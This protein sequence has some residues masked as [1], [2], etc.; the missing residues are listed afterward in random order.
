MSEQHLVIVG[1]VAAGPKIAAKARRENP[2]IPITLITDEPIISYAGCGTPYYLG[3]TFK[4]RSQLL[5]RTVG[6]FCAKNDTTM[7]VE[8]RVTKIDR[9]AHTLEVL[10]LNKQTTRT[11]AYSKLALATGA[12]AFVPPLEGLPAEG[13]F[14]LRSVTDAFAIDDWINLHSVRQVAIVGA[15]YIGLEMAE[16]LRERGLQVSVIE[17]APQV[18]PRFDVTVAKAV[19]RE[20]ERLGC[21][22]LLDTKVSG[23]QTDHRNKVTAVR[24]SKGPV[25]AEMVILSIGVRANTGLAKDAGLTIGKTGAIWVDHHM[26]TSDPDIYAA[27][28]CAE[29]TNRQTGEP[30]WVPLGSTANKQGRVAAVNMTGGHDHFPGVIGTALVRV[31]Q[32]N[33]GV[34][35]LGEMALVAGGYDYESVAVPVN[36][37]PGYI[38]GSAE[39]TLILHADR[40]SRKV[41]G[42]Q[43]FGPGEVDK[44]IDILATAITAGMTI[45]DLANL[46]LGY[47]PP[48]AP[49]MDAVIVAGNVLRNKLDGRTASQLPPQLEADLEMRPIVL[50]DC[51][52][53]DEY[54]SG[55]LPG[56]LLMPLGTIDKR[57]HELDPNAET[58]VYCKRGGRS[59]S[60]YRKLK[61]AGLK[62]VRY[63]EG[64]TTGW[65]GRTER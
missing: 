60:G 31:G 30:C 52:E 35:G 41:L 63:L 57:A 27:G 22:V 33:V 59:A 9:E 47:A 10:D 6:D 16:Q 4:Q 15:G 44:R 53:P 61:R 28:D 34:T 54:A 39:L 55:H 25:A 17:L 11:I 1:G 45:D 37:K 12:S 46:D 20:L 58:V 8:H 51:R 65:T 56:A 2:D 49:A 7:L 43:C 40:Q 26:R 62:N 19:E 38:P 64:G 36:D 5:V 42:A 29:Q 32:V 14:V 24:T 21:E 23:V 18:L 48:F 13:V 3:G 50:V